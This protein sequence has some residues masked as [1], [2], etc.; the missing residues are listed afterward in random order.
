MWTREHQEQA[1]EIALAS[2]SSKERSQLA[3]GLAAFMTERSYCETR[4]E[5]AINGALT[6]ALECRG[7]DLHHGPIKEI[8]S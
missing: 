1:I 4:G 7:I 6:D 8:E 2:L 3:A 5:R